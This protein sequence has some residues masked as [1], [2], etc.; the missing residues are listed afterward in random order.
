MKFVQG[1]AF[2]VNYLIN[3][4]NYTMGKYHAN[5]LY[6][7]WSLNSKDDD[8][9]SSLIWSPMLRIYRDVRHHWLYALEM[10]EVSSGI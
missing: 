10:K 7:K 5:R 2:A 6:P 4:N 9:R 3:G 1:R 8:Q